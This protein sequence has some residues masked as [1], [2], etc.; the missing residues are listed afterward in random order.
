VRPEPLS[1]HDQGHVAVLVVE[2]EGT[3]VGRQRGDVVHVTQVVGRD[4]VREGGVAGGRRR[5]GRGGAVGRSVERLVRRHDELTTA[6]VEEENDL[7]TEIKTS[8]LQ[9]QPFC[10][11]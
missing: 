7:A 1:A 11:G 8:F 10:L 6:K 9:L 5:R 2:E 4:G 3:D